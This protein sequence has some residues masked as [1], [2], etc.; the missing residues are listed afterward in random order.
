LT[1]FRVAAISLKRQAA[2]AVLSFFMGEK[3]YTLDHIYEIS[4]IHHP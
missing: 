2:F 1:P 4:Y 3:Q